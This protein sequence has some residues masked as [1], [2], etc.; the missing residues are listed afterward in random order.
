V[1]VR[2]RR[3]WLYRKMREFVAF[4]EGEEGGEVINK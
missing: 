2:R 4:D 3:D 1:S